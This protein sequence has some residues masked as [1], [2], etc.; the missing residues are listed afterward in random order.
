VLEHVDDVER[1]IAEIS[2]VLRRGGL[3]VYDT[4]NR[5][6]ASHLVVIKVLQD[7]RTTRFMPANLHSWERFVTPAELI[8]AM[9]RHGL[10]S[11]G[12]TGLKPVANPIRLFGLLRR[13]R[14]GE[15]SAVELGHAAV[16]AASRDASILYIGHARKG[17]AVADPAKDPNDATER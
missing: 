11:L 6:L 14:R 17:N 16:M 10:H 7:W 2:R 4:I 3:F 5:T 9:D 13:Q 12:H 8:A 1:V 15:I